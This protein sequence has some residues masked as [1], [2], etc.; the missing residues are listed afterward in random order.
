M[1]DAKRDLADPRMLAS[2]PVLERGMRW[3]LM[4]VW[5]PFWVAHAPIRAFVAV[6]RRVLL[7]VV[8]FTGIVDLKDM[9]MQEK[10]LQE[11]RCRL[12]A[13]EADL[14]ELRAALEAKTE[15][16]SPAAGPDPTFP[17]PMHPS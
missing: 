16:R 4:A 5:T 12:V 10:K 2:R 3:L 7:A 11:A 15:V 1:G 8:T 17:I 14:A 6:V 13:A 9:R